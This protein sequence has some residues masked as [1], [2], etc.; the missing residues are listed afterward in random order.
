MPQF[1]EQE[2][3]EPFDNFEFAHSTSGANAVVDVSK[4]VLSV[5]DAV[6]LLEAD[7]ASVATVV[8][9]SGTHV[10]PTGPEP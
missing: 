4:G 10:R 9:V 3:A 5:V 8:A 7:D 1:G 6:V 2:Q